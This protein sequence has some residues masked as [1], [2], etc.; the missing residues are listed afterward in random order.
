[1]IYSMTSSN[2]ENFGRMKMEITPVDNCSYRVI[3]MNLSSD[4]LVTTSED[5]VVFDHDSHSYSIEFDDKSDY[6][7][8]T[9]LVDYLNKALHGTPITASLDES[10]RV[11]FTSAGEVFSIHFA[12]HRARLLLGLINAKNIEPTNSLLCTE[13]PTTCMGNLIYLVSREGDSVK[14]MDENSMQD[15]TL[16]AIINTYTLPHVPLVLHKRNGNIIPI[17]AHQHQLS[18]INFELVDKYFEP[19]VLTSPMTVFI[20]ISSSDWGE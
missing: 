7:T 9:N 16:L 19:V 14:V 3:G 10:G 8:T 6:G 2:P 20:E 12:T 13:N 1:M 18:K 5:R 17:E 15:T 11:L 4:F